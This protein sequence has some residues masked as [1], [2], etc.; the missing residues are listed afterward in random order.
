[1]SPYFMLHAHHPA[2]PPAH[3][4][5]FFEPSEFTNV[6]LA[7]LNVLDGAISVDKLGIIAGDNLCIAL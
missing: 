2:F 4:A 1:M 5:R 6:Q 3:V 7:T